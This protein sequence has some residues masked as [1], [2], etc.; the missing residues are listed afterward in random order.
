[1]SK[2]NIMMDLETLGTNVNAAIA[3]LGVVFFD[4]KEIFVKEQ[5]MIDINCPLNRNREITPSTLQWWLLQLR[6]NHGLDVNLLGKT[7]LAHALYS[8]NHLIE[9]TVCKTGKKLGCIWGNS[10]E[11]DNAIMKHAFNQM[12][13]DP[14]FSSFN[15]I[16]CPWEYWQGR[17][18]R[19]VVQ[20]FEHVL[21]EEEVA[22]LENKTKHD[23]LADAVHQTQKLQLIVQKLSIDLK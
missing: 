20:L 6:K 7:P 10:P 1:M 5:W 12:A 23:S 21:T 15:I 11:F 16:T 9:D 4:E 18:Y 3:S 17:D 19:T 13:A 2:L 8:F 22:S 14:R